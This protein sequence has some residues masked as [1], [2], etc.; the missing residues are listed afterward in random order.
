LVQFSYF[1]LKTK[2]YIV[3]FWFF[4]VISNGFGFGLTWFFRFC[5]LLI[6]IRFGFLNILIGL[7]DFFSQFGFFYCFSVFFNFFAHF[8]LVLNKHQ[9]SPR[10]IFLSSIRYYNFF[11]CISTTLM[12]SI[13]L[14][15]QKWG[16]LG[17]NPIIIINKTFIFVCVPI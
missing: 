2:N 14:L 3:F 16:R 10:I 6:L 17:L 4:F 11:N 1:I 9:T 8:Y 13:G 5:F 12:F 7:I 15:V